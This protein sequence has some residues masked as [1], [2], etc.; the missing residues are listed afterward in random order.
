MRVAVSTLRAACV[1]LS[2]SVRRVG[3]QPR[4]GITALLASTGSATE[5]TD[6]P[7]IVCARVGAGVVPPVRPLLPI[8]MAGCGDRPSLP[9]NVMVRLAGSGPPAH[10]TLP[11]PIL[12]SAVSAACTAAAVALNAIAAVVWLP[13]VRV[14]L[15]P[16]GAPESDKVWTSL[17]SVPVAV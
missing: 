4:L 6:W 5:A 1:T 10:V 13:K 15:P 17:T 8:A 11:A 12:G 9:V 7:T 16:V 2:T 14:K 3:S